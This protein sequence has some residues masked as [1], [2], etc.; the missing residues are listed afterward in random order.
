MQINKI[1]EIKGNAISSAKGH[2][3]FGEVKVA[4][5]FTNQGRKG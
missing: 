4:K 1:G 5:S 3:Q 2:M